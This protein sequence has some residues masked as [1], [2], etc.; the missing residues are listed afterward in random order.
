MGL[1]GVQ[2]QKLLQGWE[3]DWTRQ[4]R[5]WRAWGSLPLREPTIH[6]R[7]GRVRR[8]AWEQESGGGSGITLSSVCTD[9]M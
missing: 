8:Q 1:A 7:P 5:E 6:P 9:C 4:L 3:P 2:E